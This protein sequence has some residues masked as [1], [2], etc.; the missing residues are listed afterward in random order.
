[1]TMPFRLNRMSNEGKW[2]SA[3]LAAGLVLVI[4][5]AVV[6]FLLAAAEGDRL[7]SARTERDFLAAKRN[8][9][10]GGKPS[11]LTATDDIDPVFLEGTTPGLALAALQRR[12]EAMTLDAGVAL[13]RSQPLQ[14]ENRDGLAVIR[15]EVEATG[16][17]TALRDFLRAMEA[18]QPFVF[19]NQAKLAPA[20]QGEADGDGSLPS[21]RLI[22]S[23]QL[24]AYGWQETNP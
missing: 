8:A 9:S 3:I 18:G 14:T 1:M 19:V 10:T 2:G 23:L 7:S 21:D 13:L 20:G 4:C 22:A 16:S 17:L 11:G 5:L 24:E 15:M 6:P 12:V